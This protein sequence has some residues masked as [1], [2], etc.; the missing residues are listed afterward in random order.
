MGLEFKSLRGQGNSVSGLR[1][2]IAGVLTSLCRGSW[3]YLLSRPEP[4]SGMLPEYCNREGGG[5]ACRRDVCVYIYI[6]ICMSYSLN[7]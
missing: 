6:Y 4:P 7:S 5:S 3:V 2:G 1:M